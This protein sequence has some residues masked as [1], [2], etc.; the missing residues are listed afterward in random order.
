MYFLSLLALP[1]V[2]TVAIFAY[3]GY[4]PRHFWPSNLPHLLLAQGVHQRRQIGASTFAN[5]SR[6]KPFSLSEEQRALYFQQ[7]WLHLPGVLPPE[8]L[9]ELREVLLRS[10]VPLDPWNFNGHLGH[11]EL[12]DFYLF[13]PLGQIAS[14]VWGGD[15]FLWNDFRHWR[16]KDYSVT[17]LHWD[18]GECEHML[19]L[20]NQTAR[21]R[22]RFFVSLDDHAPGPE[23]YSQTVYNDV[24]PQG[25]VLANYWASTLVDSRPTEESAVFLQ[26]AE[27]AVKY[28]L[29]ES[30]LAHKVRPHVRLGDVIMHSPCLLHGS[31]PFRE[32]RLLGALYP[33]YQPQESRFNFTSGSLLQIARVCKH[34]VNLDDLIAGHPCFPRAYPPPD[35][36]RGKVVDFS[37]MGSHGD[38]S[39]G[40]WWRV[41]LF[42]HFHK[43]RSW[44]GFADFTFG[45]NGAAE[46]PLACLTCKAI[47]FISELIIG[48]A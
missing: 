24:L 1:W 5:S 18:G 31:P 39:L 8:L 6:Y 42:K 44:P 23:I 33:T 32:E 30:H 34:N 46:R 2:P 16:E 13:S 10:G 40:H 28:I 11:D 12:L 4:V 37:F 26:S 21:T 43:M 27:E 48:P 38:A 19:L 17:P 22:L 14:Q 25:Q 41:F 20:A 45:G 29:N 3:L 36:L 15:A 35:H 9:S 47:W 7:G